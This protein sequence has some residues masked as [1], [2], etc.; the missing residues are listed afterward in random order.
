MIVPWGLIIIILMDK[1]RLRVGL[2]SLTNYTVKTLHNIT[3][4]G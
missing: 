3:W 4:E 1:K 2:N